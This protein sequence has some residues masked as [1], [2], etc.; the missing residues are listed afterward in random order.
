MIKEKYVCEYCGSEYESNKDAE[1][2]LKNHLLKMKV[3]DIN[4]IR[5]ETKSRYFCPCINKI[6]VKDENGKIW[7]FK[8]EKKKA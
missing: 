1:E 3:V 8:Q 7:N 6:S 2:C 4:F 5:D